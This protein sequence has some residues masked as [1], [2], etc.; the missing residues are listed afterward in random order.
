MQDNTNLLLVGG[1]IIAAGV[2]IIAKF[3]SNKKKDDEPIKPATPK[4]KQQE[5]HGNSSKVV[6]TTPT[7]QI[8]KE[9]FDKITSAKD[10]FIKNISNFA[11]L[12]PTLRANMNAQDWKEA[13]VAT[14]NM[15]LLQLWKQLQNKSE[16]WETVLQTWGIK[17]EDCSSFTAIQ[18][19]K[20]MYRLEDGSDVVIGNK[21]H[22]KQPC[23]VL[24]TYNV[25]DKAVKHIVSVGI[26]TKI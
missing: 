26:V 8:M 9:N 3:L 11:P 4:V 25:N 22:V 16:A 1:L 7:P 5:I 17:C 13:I 18:A 12:L 15:P 23:W 10:A 19:Y 6:A 24:T 21:Y 2:V 14:Q 20:D